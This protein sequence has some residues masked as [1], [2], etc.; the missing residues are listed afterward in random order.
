MQERRGTG[1]TAETWLVAN[2]GLL[3]AAT[4]AVLRGPLPDAEADDAAQ[5]AALAIWRHWRDGY[6]PR[7]GTRERWA[8]AIATRRAIDHYRRQRRRRRYVAAGVL[9]EAAEVARGAWDS[10]DVAHLVGERDA[11]RRA[12]GQLTP[13]ERQAVA[14]LAG[15]R[16]WAAAAAALHC[17]VGTLKSRLY[18]MRQR[19]HGLASAA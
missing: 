18:R 12:W 17:P 14:L 6:D 8:S 15:G 10:G 1:E 11:L 2:W 19:L 16:S 5:E 9:D 4:R 3:R 13:A 7:L